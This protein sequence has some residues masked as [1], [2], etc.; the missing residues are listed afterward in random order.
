MDRGGWDSY[1]LFSLLTLT[2]SLIAECLAVLAVFE[3]EFEP[4]PL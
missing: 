1:P 2:P 4:A 3:F